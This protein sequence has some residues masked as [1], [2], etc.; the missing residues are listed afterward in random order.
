MSGSVCSPADSVDSP[1]RSQGE[2]TST[3]N[4][5][6]WHSSELRSSSGT[7]APGRTAPMTPHI[8]WPP[9][10]N[11]NVAPSETSNHLS[12]SD[13]PDSVGSSTTEVTCPSC[14]FDLDESD[15]KRREWM[16]GI[17]ALTYSK[18]D[19]IACPMDGCAHMCSG[20]ADLSAHLTTNHF[21]EG[22][23]LFVV[24]SKLPHR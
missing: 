2:R 10:G 24:F 3:C 5:R 14:G 11:V 20:R 4:N 7:T 13:V 22:K 23:P 1:Q 8:V 16:S 17:R 6:L 18:T 19:S 9:D 15:S 21:P 12:E